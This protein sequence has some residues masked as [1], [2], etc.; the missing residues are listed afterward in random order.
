MHVLRALIVASLIALL[1]VEAHAAVFCEGVPQRVSLDAGGQVM[2]A[3]GG[4]PIHALCNTVVQDGYQT[5]PQQ[6]RAVYAAL[7]TASIAGKAVRVY[8]GSDALS[9]CSQVQGWS[10]QKSFYF[11]EVL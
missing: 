9:T 6:C 5:V 1:P 8:Y 7:L 11:I 3:V 2:A 10:Q 4:V